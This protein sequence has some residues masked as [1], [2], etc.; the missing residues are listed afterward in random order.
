MSGETDARALDAIDALLR[1]TMADPMALTWNQDRP[2]LPSEARATLAR[3]AAN[4]AAVTPGRSRETVAASEDQLRMQAESFAACAAALRAGDPAQVPS[5]NPPGSGHAEVLE[6][7]TDAGELRALMVA[8]SAEAADLD[9]AHVVLA[10]EFEA[11]AQACLSCA[12]DLQRER[13][14]LHGADYQ[15][16]LLA[17]LGEEEAEAGRREKNAGKRAEEVR[18]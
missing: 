12:L 15:R 6:L 4:P 3:H 10:L 17:A 1:E 5:A 13:H 18:A 7:L 9:A 16:V 14:R 2:L 11:A 8:G